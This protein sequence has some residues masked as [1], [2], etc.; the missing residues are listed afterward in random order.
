MN[1]G[2]FL[3]MPSIKSGGTQFSHSDNIYSYRVASLRIH[4]ERAI[5]RLK[6][7]AVLQFLEEPLYK[8]I[9]DILLVLA[10]VCNNMDPLIKVK[11]DEKVEKPEHEKSDIEKELTEEELVDEDFDFERL[12]QDP[13]ESS[14]SQ[15]EPET[16]AEPLN[17]VPI[18]QPLNF[19]SK[20]R[21]KKSAS[22]ETSTSG[23]TSTFDA[24][25]KM[26]VAELKAALKSRGLDDKGKKKVLIERLEENFDKEIIEHEFD[27]DERDLDE[28]GLDEFDLDTNSEE[29][30]EIEKK[31]N[32]LDDVSSDEEI[33]PLVHKKKLKPDEIETILNADNDEL[34]VDINEP[35]AA[36]DEISADSNEPSVVPNEP[37]TSAS[38]SSSRSR[39]RSSK[40][41]DYVL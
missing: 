2:C 4:V 7:F 11:D 29:N 13:T 12:V 23:E 30:D 17:I 3:I 32:F 14:A 38:R 33:G 18:I 15:D 10:Y 19:S 9:N 5:E 21:G 34:S 24:I 31:R 1:S 40:Y 25:N 26:K 36:S 16:S 41:D 8:Y 28:F 22:K 39:K 20:K 6:T 37:T 35:S 27:L